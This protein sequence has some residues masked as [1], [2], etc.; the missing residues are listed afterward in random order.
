MPVLTDNSQRLVITGSTFHPLAA[1]SQ[2]TQ[3]DNLE[4]LRKLAAISPTLREFAE[5]IP[6]PQEISGRA[7]TR[8]VLTDYFPVVGLLQ[9]RTYLNL[10]YGSKGLA[11]APLA[12]E[13][14]ADMICKSPLPLADELLNRLSPRRFAGK[15]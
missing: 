11:L 1:D 14:I 3:E 2:A 4:N 7:S 9:P 13:I 10:G 15:N 5:A 12:G 8:A 6:T